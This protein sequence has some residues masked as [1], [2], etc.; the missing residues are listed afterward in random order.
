MTDPTQ[1]ELAA[2]AAKLATGQ[3]STAEDF[4]WL[5]ERALNLWRGAGEALSERRSDQELFDYYANLP[6]DIAFRDAGLEPPKRVRNFKLD[7]ALRFLMPNRRPADRM[8]SFRDYLTQTDF[9]VTFRGLDPRE[10]DEIPTDEQIK[11]IRESGLHFNSLM[12]IAQD[13]LPWL[14]NDLSNKRKQSGEMGGKVK[15]PKRKTS[16]KK[17]GGG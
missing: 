14:K 10:A 8:K 7:E 4:R 15:R 13:F 3:E 2:L 11:R 12:V 6:D 5:A 9:M 1:S 16:A 17:K